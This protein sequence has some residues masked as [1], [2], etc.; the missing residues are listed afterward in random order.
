[1]VAHNGFKDLIRAV[2]NW[3]PEV[4]NFFD[5]GATNAYT[6]A[7]NG[8]AKIRNRSGR[9]YS[10][11]AI[12]AKILY[13]GKS[14]RGRFGESTVD[15]KLFAELTRPLRKIPQGSNTQEENGGQ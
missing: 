3:K 14:K 15:E 13:G 4:L 9:G 1:M 10:F 11:D 8:L 6:E 7:A 2:G 12:R 5:C